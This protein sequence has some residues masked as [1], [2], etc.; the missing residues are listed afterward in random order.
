MCIQKILAR[1][2][3]E[4]LK[5]TTKAYSY[6][7]LYAVWQTRTANGSICCPELPDV[8]WPLW[9][10][11]CQFPVQIKCLLMQTNLCNTCH[12]CIYQI[13]RDWQ[14]PQPS[15]TPQPWNE[16]D[17]YVTLDHKSTYCV[18]GTTF[19]YDCRP[20]T[21]H[22]NQPIPRQHST[23]KQRI[24]IKCHFC[25]SHADAIQLNEKVCFILLYTH[26]HT[27]TYTLI[28][29]YTYTLINA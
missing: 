13:P 15:P 5:Y 1:V 16:E 19:C 25:E 9:Q 3:N 28:H 14:H 21:N 10:K 22:L 27:Y 17:D 7:K 26:T 11:R 23:E 18:C 2:N 8:T 29:T 6:R 12:R 24:A 20:P 4:N